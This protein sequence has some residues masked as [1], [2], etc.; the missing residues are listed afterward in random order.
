MHNFINKKVKK[1]RII[2]I[3]YIFYINKMESQKIDSIYDEAEYY[4]KVSDYSS[5]YNYKNRSDF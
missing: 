5:T 3:Q 2:I 1:N 4:D